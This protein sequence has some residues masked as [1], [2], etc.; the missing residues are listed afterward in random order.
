MALFG[1]GV[2]GTSSQQATAA[3]GARQR[4]T[5]S[6]TG[7]AQQSV[8]L[9]GRPG[10]V[11]LQVLERHHRGRAGALR[12]TLPLDHSNLL[13]HLLDLVPQQAEEAHLDE[14]DDAETQH[15]KQVH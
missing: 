12:R 9:H 7:H 11:S 4:P 5:S 6:P 15:G 13:D 10:E 8:L 3:R 2:G 14:G 1:D